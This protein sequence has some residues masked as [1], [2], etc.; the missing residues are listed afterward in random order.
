MASRSPYAAVAA[1]SHATLSGPYVV[2]VISSTS[3]PATGSSALSSSPPGP[4]GSAYTETLET[5]T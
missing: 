5:S 2:S 1:R 3:S 4:G